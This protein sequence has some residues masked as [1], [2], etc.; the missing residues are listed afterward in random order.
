MKRSVLPFV[1]LAVIF[2]SGIAQNADSSLKAIKSQVESMG[3]DISSLQKAVDD[4]YWYNRVGDVAFIDKVFITG[5]PI[6]EKQVKNPTAM[7]V[8]NPVKFYCYVFVPKE[9]K[10]DRKY[11][12]LVL[13]HGGVHAD[14]TTY[15]AHIIRELMAQQYIVIAPEYRGSTGYGKEFF[16]KID[17]GGLENE[18][19]NASRDYMVKNY[20]IVDST[21]V[22]I[23]GWSH[24]G[25]I[26][27]MCVFD[28]PEKYKVCFAGN[29]VS[30]L[31]ARM[32][33]SDDEYRKLFSVDYH[34]GKDAKDDIKEYRR[35]SPAWN[36]HKLK[37]PLLIHT[38]TNDDDV[39]SLEVEHLIQALKAEG[40]QFE[41]EIFKDVE[42]G[43]S[44]DRI[45]TRIGKQIRLKIYGFLDKYLDPP[46]K[47][48]TLQDMDKAGYGK[49]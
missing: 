19:V 47:M 18:D 38:N 25:M 9:I 32:G 10:G 42:G 5:P 20:G 45:D 37:T 30:D 6:S 43:H 22:G 21:R 3:Y 11:P 8:H 15:H 40:K 26:A 41:Y 29:P 24:G 39:N 12:M 44:F 46:G 4:I 13:P 7:G 14:F 49:W 35:R 1:V 16:E 17:Y 36:A 34:L 33:Y 2:T 27:L 23:I 48:K 31:V 28:H